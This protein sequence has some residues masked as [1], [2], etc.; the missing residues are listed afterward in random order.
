MG[1]PLPADEFERRG[2]AQFGSMGSQPDWLTR[3][4]DADESGAQKP[5][6][7]KPPGPA[8]HLPGHGPAAPADPDSWE[9]AVERAHNEARFTY[10]DQEALKGPGI[11][12]RTVE[13]IRSGRVTSAMGGFASTLSGLSRSKPV[14]IAA[15]AVIAVVA[16]MVF[17][18]KVEQTT[19]I[20]AVQ[21]HPERFEGQPVKI[22]G[23][24][25]EV[26]V[27]GGSYAFNLQQG[28]EHI[29][30]FTRSRVPVRGE[31][32]TI[33]GSISAGT[34]DGKTRQALFETP[35]Q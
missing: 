33:I 32:V 6:R 27:V 19:S 10:V 23:R 17:R 14:I 16:A 11:V 22:R 1:Q 25:G 4:S 7:P 30:V 26:F 8:L 18:P 5:A 12:D 3:V 13:A 34:L 28:R 24:V 21:R 9:G 35:P 29:V 31:E 2:P 15:L 20:A